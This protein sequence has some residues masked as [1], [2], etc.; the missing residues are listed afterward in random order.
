MLTNFTQIPQIARILFHV[1]QKSQE[2]QKE[3]KLAQL[4]IE[5]GKLGRRN[6]N[7]EAGCEK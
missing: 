3:A 2:P 6:K 4:K 7:R 1:S 5:N